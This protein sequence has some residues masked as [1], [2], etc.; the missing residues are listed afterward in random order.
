[1]INLIALCAEEKL[2]NTFK[3]KNI[4]V[5]SPASV[6]NVGCGFDVFAFALVQPGDEIRLALKG[7]MGVKIRKITGI[8]SLPMEAERNT[9]GVS[10]LTM[11]KYINA[12]FGIDMEIHKKMPYKSGLGSSAASAVGSVFALNQL[13]DLNLSN[14]TLLKFAMEGEKIAS[15]NQVHL[16]NIAACLYG[17]FI[18]ARSQNPIDIISIPVP[19]N[20]YCVILHPHIEIDTSDA[21]Q[22]LP[23]IIGL[24]QAVEQWGNTAAVIS[25]LYQKD[26][27]LLK[28]S[29]SDN[30]IEPIRAR[31]I[32]FFYELKEKALELGS[33]GCSIAGSGPSV[34]AFTESRGSAESVGIGMTRFYK[35]KN[36]PF[37]TYVTKINTDGPRVL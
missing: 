24:A 1:V 4:R 5:F 29:V 23:K 6:A 3:S 28:R 19:D 8:P 22:I 34:F 16:D 7:E 32:P 33:L 36:I 2:M 15:W 11:L 26:Y 14:E 13:L 27:D 20:L 10:L 21:R 37:D 35:Q 25:A 17:G 30:I 9:A 18:L 31:Q 12:D